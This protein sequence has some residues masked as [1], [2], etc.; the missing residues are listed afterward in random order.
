[1]LQIQNIRLFVFHDISYDN[2]ELNVVKILAF[3]LKEVY[4]SIK[5]NFT[6]RYKILL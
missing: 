3:Q 1:M 4:G 5:F 2:V 6:L